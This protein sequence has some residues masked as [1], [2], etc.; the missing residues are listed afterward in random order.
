[1]CIKNFFFCYEIDKFCN[2][3]VY[4]FDFDWKWFMFVLV[5]YFNVWK[6]EGFGVYIYLF[7]FNIG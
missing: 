1:M 2:F 5:D 4:V 3:L 6:D 7:C